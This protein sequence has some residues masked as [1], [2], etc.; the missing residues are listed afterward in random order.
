MQNEQQF[1][2]LIM[3][4]NQLKNGSADI[5]K[6]IEAEEFDEAI[7]ML[8]RREELFLSCKCM[9]NYLELTPVQ[10]KEL[11]TLLDELRLMELENIRI[12]ERGM[13][14]VQKELKR[15]QQNEKIQQAYDFDE[16]QSGNIINYEE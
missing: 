15:T 10:E 13:A 3:Q 14:E 7:S 5:R 9:R 12:L 2:Q 6:M 1:E 8:N 11:N 16:N 4:Y